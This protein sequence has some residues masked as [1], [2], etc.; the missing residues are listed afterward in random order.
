MSKKKKVYTPI[1]KIK[2][3]R[4]NSVTTHTLYDMEKG[5]YKC[6]ICKTIHG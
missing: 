6:V 4:C 5:I 1:V 2:C 3:P